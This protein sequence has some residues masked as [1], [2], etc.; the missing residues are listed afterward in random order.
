MMRYAVMIILAWLVSGCGKRTYTTVDHNDGY[1]GVAKL[2]P[3][4]AAQTLLKET[5]EPNYQ[6]MVRNGFVKYDY[7]TGMVISPASTI[8]SEF[9]VDKML[10]WV[11]NGGVYVCLLERG[12]KRWVDVGED[13]DHRSSDWTWDWSFD[14]EDEQALEY[15]LEQMNIEMVDD[16]SGK[17]TGG[18]SYHGDPKDP[19]ALGEELPLVED[20][21]VKMYQ[22][23]ESLDLQVGGTK[24]MK[25]NRP[26]TYAD[27]Y[28]EGEYH[29]FL[30]LSHGEGRI[31]FVTDG[32]LFRNPYL[33]MSDHAELLETM[34]DE[35]Y[36]D[37]VFA[38]GNR[39][40]FWSLMINYAGPALLGVF[41][42]LVFWL[43]KSIP[44]FG[45]LLEIPEGH[46][47]DY[48]QS[49]SNT[50]RFLWKYKSGGV[51][52]KSMRENLLRSSGMF[53][54]EGQAE[55]SLIETFA[56]K[57]GLEVE[58]VIEALTREQV[59]EAGDMVRITRNL[60][61]ILKSL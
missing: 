16:P 28:Q 29:R 45:P 43:W 26:L 47:R 53:N 33:P 22:G 4:L 54:A 27:R 44:R 40:G 21:K 50:G 17:T 7:E 37:I 6:V 51:L 56:E 8:S 58:E 30:G 35:V 55:E 36:G 34:S 32:R 14:E 15:L 3:Y 60:Q 61:T 24:V 48:A 49:V 1:K 31:Y 59:N 25:Y 39:R 46:A 57:S 12:E 2:N 13:C 52:L 11:R 19:V 38:Y 18:R 5:H 41:V 9:M 10:R 20:V 42:L 23:G